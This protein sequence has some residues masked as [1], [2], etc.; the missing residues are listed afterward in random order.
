MKRYSRQ[1]KFLN[2]F[3]DLD[4]SLEDFVS[5]ISSKKIVLVGCG[6]VGSVLA[7]LLVRGGFNNLVLVDNDLIDETNLQRQI[8]FEAD[9][10]KFKSNALKEYLLKVNSSS[11]IEVICDVL[12]EKN[13]SKFCNKPDLIIDATDNFKTRKLIN[14]YC[15]SNKCDWIYSGAVKC[16][17]ICCLFRGKNKLFSKVFPND[18]VDESCCAVGVLSSTTFVAASFVFNRVLKYFLGIE[19][20]SLVKMNLWTYKI[21]EIKI[22]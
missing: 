19:E 11:K 9:I 4:V 3:I 8:F 18:V 20:N 21:H 1:M 2:Q 15:E 16:E 10:G 7:E 5:D 22:K 12:D 6:G 13:I 14:S 17:I